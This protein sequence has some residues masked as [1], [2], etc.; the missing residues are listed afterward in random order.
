MRLHAL[1][2]HPVKGARGVAVA[3]AEVRPRGL[4]YD[5]RWM[6]VDADG[7]FVS[8]RTHPRLRA[9][10][11]HLGADRLTLA[12]D[13]AADPTLT[14]TT[15]PPPLDL[16]LDAPAT[17]DR[18]A[19]VWG[20]DVAVAGCGPDADAWLAAWLGPGYAL[21]RH[22]RDAHR[23]VDPAY[24]RDGDAVAFADGF[25]YLVVTTASLAALNAAAGRTFDVARFRANLVV[26]GATPWAEDRW[27]HLRVGDA[28]FELVKPCVRC[29]VTTLDPAGAPAPEAPAAAR[30]PLATLARL[31]ATSKGPAFGVNA[32]AR[33]GGALHV[34][35]PVDAREAAPEATPTTSPTDL[36]G[37]GAAG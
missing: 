20:D 14:P 30:E 10:V 6:I 26:D 1:Y 7:R 24:G 33:E 31:H 16:P 5:R 12:L 21:V 28:A 2:V 35:D 15:T 17:A 22:P 4:R 27:T 36:G 8:Q 3:T 19:R 29:V 32:L 25:P 11:P 37:P 18:H 23:P 13:P 9:L 34:G